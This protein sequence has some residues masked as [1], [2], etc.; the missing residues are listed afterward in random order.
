MATAQGHMDQ[1]RKNRQST[2]RPTDRPATPL[3]TAP[4]PIARDTDNG[5]FPAQ[6]P[7]K[8][9]A[10]FAAIGLAEAH[11]GVVYTN[12]TG[13]FPVTSLSGNKYMLI[14]YDYD[15]NSIL[16]EPMESRSNYEA[17][18]AYKVLY[19][20]LTR[21]GL[22]PQLNILDNEA[23]KAI[24]PAIMKAGA[25]YQLVEPNNHCVNAAERAIR[26]FK[27]HFIAGLCSTDPRFPITLWDKLLPQAVITLNLL[28]T[29]RLNPKLSAHTQLHGVFNF[30]KTLL[31]P[32]GTRA[33]IFEDPATRASWAPHGKE[34]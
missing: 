12:L 25:N 26:T 34:T 7:I 10:V 2:K 29:S 13:A 20:E 1:A 9:H 8:T 3:H 27:N 4:E 23:S 6:S 28:R 16:V 31:A 14:L 21:H 33:L 24:K 15:S 11:N 19:T 5:L 18:R 22:Q 30:N 32:P 17:L